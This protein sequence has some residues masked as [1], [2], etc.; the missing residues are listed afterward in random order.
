M[1]NMEKIF[2]VS[3]TVNSNDK[4]SAEPICYPYGQAGMQNRLS[5]RP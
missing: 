5:A 4:M 2:R 3:F 1:V